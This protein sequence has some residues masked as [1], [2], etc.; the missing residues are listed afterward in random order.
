MVTIPA[1]S[2]PLCWRAYR[3]RYASLD[4]SGSPDTP[5]IPH[6]LFSR[7][8]IHFG[9][10]HPTGDRIKVDSPQRFGAP[11]EQLR[12]HLEF[13]SASAFTQAGPETRYATRIG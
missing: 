11:R 6:I 2:W 4:A 12:P 9:V 1:L 8:A 7:R 13:Q 5:M 10:L 3:P